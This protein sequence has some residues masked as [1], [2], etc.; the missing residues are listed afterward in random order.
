MKTELTYGDLD[1]LEF[2]LVE[3]IDR[4]RD[5]RRQELQDYAEVLDETNDAF[6][7]RVKEVKRKIVKMMED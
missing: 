2:C 6:L 3:I 5:E 4:L 1:I 7:E